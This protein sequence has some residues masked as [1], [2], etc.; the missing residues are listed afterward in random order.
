MHKNNVLFLFILLLVYLTV[1][2]VGILNIYCNSSKIK[3]LFI[4]CVYW[5]ARHY[6]NHD[7]A[8]GK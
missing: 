7:F 4:I 3:Y 1:K 5:E 8:I 6:P 2:T